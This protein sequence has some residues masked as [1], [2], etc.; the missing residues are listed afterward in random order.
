MAVQ[1]VPSVVTN[2]VLESDG[3]D[4]AAVGSA[5]VGSGPE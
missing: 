4:P 5:V 2:E 1:S 3:V